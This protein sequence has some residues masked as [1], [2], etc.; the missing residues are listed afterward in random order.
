MVAYQ[1]AAPRPGQRH[2]HVGRPDLPCLVHDG[3][4]EFDAGEFRAGRRADAGGRDHVRVPDQLRVQLVGGARCAF[5]PLGQ[6]LGPGLEHGQPLRQPGLEAW[7]FPFRIVAFFRNENRH[8]YSRHQV[9]AG[10]GGGQRRV[11]A[12]RTAIRKLGNHGG[13]GP[14]GGVIPGDGAE[15]PL[16]PGQRI[17][18]AVAVRTQ[19]RDG[20]LDAGQPPLAAPGEDAEK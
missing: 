18:R 3:Q 15:L 17:L 12:F 7:Q 8:V 14:D 20:L 1:H 4:L 10:P 6:Q 9:P 19:Q 5:M 16:S 2:E 11:P 13:G